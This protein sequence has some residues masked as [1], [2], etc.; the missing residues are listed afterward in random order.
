[1]TRPDPSLTLPDAPAG[2]WVDR[3]APAGW[4]PYLRLMRADRSIGWRLLMIPGWQ[5]I[6]LAA[7]AIAQGPWGWRAVDLPWAA[8]LIAAFFLGAVAMRGAGCVLNDMVDRDIDAAVARTRARPIPSGQ[9][10]LS[11]AAALM[12]GL[13]LIGLLILSTFPWPAIWLGLASALPIIAYPFMKRITWWPQLFLGIAFNWGALLGWTAFLGAA[14]WPEIAAP[15]ALYLGAIAWTIGYDTIY[16]HQDRED[17]AL[18]GVKSTARLF[19]ART[20]PWLTLFYTLAVI[21]A[22]AAGALAGLGWLFWL[23]LLAYAGHLGGQIMRLDIHDGPL[24]LH[25]FKSNGEAGLILLAAILL[26][27]A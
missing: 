5:S 25:L 6:A 18:I 1:M 8:W 15:I 14:D 10:S 19:G 24:C 26:G 27:A 16:A 12:A 21:G 11:G 22:G 23:G 9:V 7:A 3:A 13:C 17:D 2:N 20:K 4:R